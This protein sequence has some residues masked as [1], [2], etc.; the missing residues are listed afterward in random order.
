MPKISEAAMRAFLTF[1]DLETYLQ[2]ALDWCEKEGA[3]S[4]EEVVEES[5]DFAQSLKLKNL[6]RK[7][8]E[9]RAQEALADSRKSTAP[10]ES[11]ADSRKS[12]APA[13]SRMRGVSATWVLDVFPAM[14]KSST[15]KDSPSF[16]EIAP[17]LAHGDAGIGKGK[18]CPRDGMPD[19][20]IVDALFSEGNS[21]RSTIFLSWV[22][23]YKV[24]DVCSALAR[25]LKTQGTN[26][27][28]LVFIWWCFFTNNQFRIQSGGTVTTQDLC[29]TFGDQLKK[30][31]RMLIMMNKY[32]DPEY[33]KRIWCIFEVH[34]AAAESIKTELTLPDSAQEEFDELARGGLDSLSNLLSSID[35]EKAEA[36]VKTDETA[37]KVLIKSGAGFDRV[38]ELVEET[39]MASLTQEFSR[40]LK[41]KRLGNKSVDANVAAGSG[42]PAIRQL[43]QTTQ[44]SPE[45]TELVEQLTNG[46]PEAQE[47]SAAVLRSLLFENAE[48]QREF[49]EAG[50]IGPLIALLTTGTPKAQAHSAGALAN[51]AAN[52]ENKVKVAEAGAIGPLVALLSKGT[53]EAQAHSAGALRNLAVNNGENKVKVAEAGAIGPLVALLSK[54]TPE[55]QERSAAALRIWWLSM[56][57]TR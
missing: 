31:G 19:S 48:N 29:E 18:V 38:N 50:A 57:R 28:A 17:F 1:L 14:V 9:K 21:G 55:A 3:A 47:K 37:I 46:T 35:T 7:R 25:W 53:P 40:A 8:F 4:L 10:A 20:S 44:L 22:W 27:S 15:G 39:L 41:A 51:L 23:S 43:K 34:M 36:S 11:L 6:E 13:E 24:L 33:V 45:F 16:I 56:G 49:A 54:G 30:V 2:A 26:A 12:A 5:T 32:R 42:G 52:G